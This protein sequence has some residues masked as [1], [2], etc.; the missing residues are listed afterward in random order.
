MRYTLTALEGAEL[1]CNR[2]KCHFGVVE[3]KLLGHIVIGT[4][5][6]PDPEKCLL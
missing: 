6:S 3:L 5:I 1:F 2:K 4:N